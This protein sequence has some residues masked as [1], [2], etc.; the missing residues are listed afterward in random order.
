MSNEHVSSIRFSTALE[1]F[2]VVVSL[3][4]LV[5]SIRSCQISEMSQT[6][7]PSVAYRDRFV[8]VRD[9]FKKPCRDETG[10]GILQVEY[11]DI[12]EVSN[13]GG[14]KVTLTSTDCKL[15]EQTER[16]LIQIDSQ[17]RYL[18]SLEE[19]EQWLEERSFYRSDRMEPMKSH[20][21]LS[22]PVTVEPGETRLLVMLGRVTFVFD[23][24]VSPSSAKRMLEG[25]YWDS[26]VTF[27][28]NN[29]PEPALVSI[30]IPSPSWSAYAELS[31]EPCPSE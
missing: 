29:R 16:S 5:V 23:N 2:A 26:D 22:P 13:D 21:L 25:Q 20:L 14:K 19:L 7:Q 3:V 6:P 10:N 30:S 28:F 27:T 11:L 4:A 15:E 8:D 1:I 17:C 24:I 18:A 9:E 12:Y 31:F